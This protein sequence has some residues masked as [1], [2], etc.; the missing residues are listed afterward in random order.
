MNAD[1]GMRR[2]AAPLLPL[3]AALELE[4]VLLLPVVVE[5]LLTMSVC[6]VSL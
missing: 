6:A 5:L 3:A 2:P 4:E 1:D